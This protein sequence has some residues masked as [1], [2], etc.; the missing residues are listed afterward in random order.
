MKSFLIVLMFVGVVFS[1]NINQ[2]VYPGKYHP[3]AGRSFSGADSSYRPQYVHNNNY[4]ESAMA[5]MVTDTCDSAIIMVHGYYNST[6]VRFP[7]KIGRDQCGFMVPC[8][9][10]DKIWQTGTKVWVAG[11]VVA[12]PLEYIWVSPKND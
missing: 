7:F 5:I 2:T 11:S 1:Q 4:M 12:N 10:I 6:Q 9:A 8:G 3:L